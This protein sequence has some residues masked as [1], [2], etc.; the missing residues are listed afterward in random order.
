MSEIKNVTAEDL[1][2]VKY[3]DLL[4]K[5]TELGI[6]EVWKGGAKKA[7]LITKAVEK[8][9][10]K[11]SLESIGLDE[12]E[13]SKEVEKM[14]IKKAKAEDKKILEVA[15]Q[16]E[17]KDK[18][19]VKKIQKLKL[20]KEQ[21]ERNIKVVKGNIAGGVPSHRPMLQLKLETLLDLLDKA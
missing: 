8:L 14:A 9:K 2:E 4:A 7:T 13:V 10:I 15:K 17:A 1:N 16:E 11:A 5:F 21:I 6:P 18:A 12:E 20:T 3:H 19:V